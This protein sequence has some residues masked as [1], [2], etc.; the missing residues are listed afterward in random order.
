MRTKEGDPAGKLKAPTVHSRTTTSLAH[1]P[2]GSAVSDII[3]FGIF[4]VALTACIIGMCAALIL[5]WPS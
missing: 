1:E 5:V 3:A 4:T 2:S